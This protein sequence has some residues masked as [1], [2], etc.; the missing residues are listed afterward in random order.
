MSVLK[1]LQFIIL[2]VWLIY[3]V[4]DNSNFPPF[5]EYNLAL[6]TV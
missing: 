3:S 2:L 4:G 6:W 1:L 5:A